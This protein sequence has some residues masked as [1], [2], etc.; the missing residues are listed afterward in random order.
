VGLSRALMTTG[1]ALTERLSRE[2]LIMDGGMG[3]LLQTRG[4]P[5]GYPPDLWSFERPD[6][7]RELHEAYIEAGADIVLTNTFGATRLRLD[8]FGWGVKVFDLNRA[9]VDLAKAAAEG[10]ALVAGDIGPLAPDGVKSPRLSRQEAISVFTEQVEALISG[11]VDLL[12]IET[13]SD[14]EEMEA[15]V[16]AAKSVAPDVPILALLTFTTD[17]TLRSG[18][19]P[20]AAA[21]AL[22]AMGVQVVGANCSSGF[23]SLLPICEEMAAATALPVA[24]KP[25]AGV[26]PTSPPSAD[27]V[28]EYARRF[29]EAGANLVG[30][31]CGVGPAMLRAIAQAVKGMP[32]L[33]HSSVASPFING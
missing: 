11:G 13:I 6:E 17:G 7:V 19:G 30:G 9:S 16:G 26:P 15:V 25:S 4:L 5:R 18:E 22:E 28:A 31:C 1:A 24:M 29:V 20:A 12:A 23:Q 2:V 32:P 33:R 21:R 3:T 8:P 27:E 14:L 10:K